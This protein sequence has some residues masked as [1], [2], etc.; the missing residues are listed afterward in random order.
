MV[1]F[2]ANQADSQDQSTDV[3]CL[4]RSERKLEGYRWDETAVERMSRLRVVTHG[5]F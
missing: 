4:S 2:T 1:F 5:D 3:G